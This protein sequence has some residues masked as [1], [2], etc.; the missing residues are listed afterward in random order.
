MAFLTCF[1]K[2]LA[3]RSEIDC[4]THP[5]FHT[6]H[7]PLLKVFVIYHDDESYSLASK[8]LIESYSYLV[9]VPL[10]K[11]FEM[12][13]F[14]DSV[15]LQLD[16]G[17]TPWVGIMQYSIPKQDFTSMIN[18]HADN[19]D[20]L[21]IR[22]ESSTTLL[23]Q[24]IKMHGNEFKTCFDLLLNGLGLNP[25][26]FYDK[27]PMYRNCFIVRSNILSDYQKFFMR[28]IHLIENDHSINKAM[29]SDSSYKSNTPLTPNMLQK[30]SNTT[31]YPMFIFVLERLPAVYF[32]INNSRIKYIA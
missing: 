30:L 5:R 11:Y 21:S 20:V 10:T 31:Y 9:K 15:F 2:N 24:G 29:M 25:V 22:N 3:T 12:A 26:N 8:Y 7:N 28:A 4:Y 14:L 18:Q 27:V 1:N 17:T 16:V 23:Q 13:V 6:S 19:Y 32:K